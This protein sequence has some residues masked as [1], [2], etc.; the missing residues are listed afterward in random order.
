MKR[1]YKQ[2]EA[3]EHEGRLTVLL[4]GRPVRTPQRTLLHLPTQPLADAVAAEWHSQTD[5][6]IPASMPLTQFAATALDRVGP[7]I[8]QVAAEI[9]RFAETDLVCY[10]AETPQSLAEAEHAAWTPLL[11]WVEA[12]FDARLVVTHGITPI[13]QPSATVARLQAAVAAF[14]AFPLAALSGAT[15]ATGSVVIGLALA[16][17]RIDG[18]Q[19][20]DAAQVDEVFQMQRWGTD[21]EAEAQLAQQRADLCAAERFLALL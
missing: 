17:G 3:G 6:I 11:T 4:D 5:E 2:A 20:A 9:A 13:P 16:H 10:R 19:A 8:G 15:A 7:Q 21:P 18:N 12:T 14:E 1:F